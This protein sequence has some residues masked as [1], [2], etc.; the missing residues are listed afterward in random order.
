MSLKDEL[1]KFIPKGFGKS[2]KKATSDSTELTRAANEEEATASQQQQR[3]DKTKPKQKNASSIYPGLSNNKKE[4]HA[5][6]PQHTAQEE[7][8]NDTADSHLL[9]SSIPVSKY[10]VLPGNKKAISTLTWDASGDILCSGTRTGE[11][12]LWD[13]SRM[14]G[15][16]QATRKFHP[17]EEG[18]RQQ[19]RMARFDSE[20]TRIL[21]C[22][23]ADPRAKLFDCTGRFIREFKR[24]DMYVRDMRRTTGHVAPLTCVDWH[25]GNTHRFITAAADSTV[26][27]WDCERSSGQERVILAKTGLRNTRLT[28]S[29]CA[30]SADGSL[31]GMGQVQDGALALWPAI[32][33][34]SRPAHQV[35]KAHAPGSDISLV[36]LPDFQRIL[37]RGTEDSTVKL[38]DI[39]KI[40]SPL[41]VATEMHAAGP[42]SDL[43]LSPDGR[44][45]VAGLARPSTGGNNLKSEMAVLN[46]SDL[47]LVQKIVS[48]FSSGDAINICWHPR[49]NQIA[50]SSSE[51]SACVLY[52]EDGVRGGAILCANKKIVKRQA[53]EATGPIITPHA[54]PLFK[55]EP[56]QSSAGA[57]RRR[58]TEMLKSKPGMPQYGHGS[59]GN[60]GVN[61]TQHIMKSII[62]DTIRDEDPRE[63]LLRY[64][65][66][67]EADP[68]FISP[69]YKE[70]QDKPVFDEDFDESET[71]PAM[72]RRK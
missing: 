32:E 24:G 54:L 3:S 51:G 70:T 41:A 50:A 21:L 36:F 69:A 44:L 55:D 15:S 12:S 71:T 66:V 13:F 47:S 64:A 18:Q 53:I 20:G 10:I 61:E 6:S 22:S 68:V 19:I 16:F 31:I 46:T 45:V 39:R 48:P 5:G 23:S 28:I 72:K 60:I 8:G 34:K 38:W 49:I 26:R 37:T 2:K 33:G 25:P 1:S 30:Y 7:A 65:S 52:N 35:D 29:S 43:A 9:E 62:K 56:R 57:K 11:V 4:K 42:E 14:D 63:A 27:V 40:S 17:Y 58:E 59:G 67:A